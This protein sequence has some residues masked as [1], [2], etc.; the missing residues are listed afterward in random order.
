MRVRRLLL[1]GLASL[2]G[3]AT[4]AHAAPRQWVSPNGRY[5]LQ[6]PAAPQETRTAI[7][8]GRVVTFTASDSTPAGQVSYSLTAT[9]ADSVRRRPPNSRVVDMLKLETDTFARS[10]GADPSMLNYTWS[11][12]VGVGTVLSHPL[13]FR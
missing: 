10:I 12:R 13:I 2:L 8:G 4:V 7:Q 11:D 3:E 9:V 5:S 1:V 6:F